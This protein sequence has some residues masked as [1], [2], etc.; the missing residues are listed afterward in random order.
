MTSLLTQRE[1]CRQ[2]RLSVKTLQRLRKS[3]RIEAI[4]ISHRAVRFTQAA[5]DRF[6]KENT[7]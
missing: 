2:L 6:L 1:V 7:R 5:V 4:V 3:K